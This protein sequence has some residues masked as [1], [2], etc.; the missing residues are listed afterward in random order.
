[1]WAVDETF[2]TSA[3]GG[4]SGSAGVPGGAGQLWEA[5]WGRVLLPQLVTGLQ[6]TFLPRKLSPESNASAV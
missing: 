3:P 4:L 6:T 5:S 2:Q 1:M